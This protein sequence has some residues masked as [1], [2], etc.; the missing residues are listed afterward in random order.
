MGKIRKMLACAFT[1]TGTVPERFLI[2]TLKNPPHKACGH[3]PTLYPHLDEQ[4]WW[5]K[6]LA[7]C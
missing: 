3:A 5:A 7:R 2:K 4:I 6:A 1:T